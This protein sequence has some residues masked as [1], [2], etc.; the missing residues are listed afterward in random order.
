MSGRRGRGRGG[1]RYRGRSAR[2]ATAGGKAVKKTA[3]AAPTPDTSEAFQG[4]KTLIQRGDEQAALALLTECVTSAGLSKLSLEEAQDEQRYS[5]FSERDRSTQRT[6]L[7]Y[8]AENGQDRAVAFLLKNGADPE[9]CDNKRQ[10]PLDAAD[11]ALKNVFSAHKKKGGTTKNSNKGKHG[12]NGSMTTPA[13]ILAGGSQPSAVAGACLDVGTSIGPGHRTFRKGLEKT[14][15]VTARVRKAERIVI[16]AHRIVEHIGY[17]CLIETVGSGHCP[18]GAHI[19]ISRWVVRHMGTNSFCQ[20]MREDKSLQKQDALTLL[21]K[22]EHD[23][24]SDKKSNSEGAFL[25]PDSVLKIK[26][27]EPLDVWTVQFLL[28]FLVEESANFRYIDAFTDVLVTQGTE[29]LR[30]LDLKTYENIG[31]MLAITGRRLLYNMTRCGDTDESG[32]DSDEE[33]D[34][35]DSSEEAFFMSLFRT[36]TLALLP[37]LGSLITKCDIED[38]RLK[39]RMPALLSTESLSTFAA[40]VIGNDRALLFLHVT[41]PLVNLFVETFAALELL[42]E[43]VQNMRRFAIIMRVF[44]AWGQLCEEICMLGGKEEAAHHPLNERGPKTKKSGPKKSKKQT[45]GDPW[46]V[47]SKSEEAFHHAPREDDTKKKKSATKIS[48]KQAEDPLKSGKCPPKVCEGPG[49]ASVGDAVVDDLSGQYQSMFLPNRFEGVEYLGT[50]LNRRSRR[51]SQYRFDRRGVTLSVAQKFLTR[52][53]KLEIP[54]VVADVLVLHKKSLMVMVQSEPVL[55]Q[56]VLDIL[57][58]VPSAVS[59][60]VKV[61]AIIAAIRR[62]RD[63]G[64]EYSWP[65]RINR[66]VDMTTVMETVVQQIV[67]IPPRG[68]VGTLNVEFEGEDGIGDGPVREFFDL[69]SKQLLLKPIGGEIP[70]FEEIQPGVLYVKRS[71][72]AEAYSMQRV[73]GKLSKS[74]KKKR[75]E[76]T[77]WVLQEAPEFAAQIGKHVY[78]PAFGHA[79]EEICR[80]DK[81]ALS[82]PLARKIVSQLLNVICKRRLLYQCV[83]RIMGLAVLTHHPLSVN[84]SPLVFKQLLQQDFV[85]EDMIDVDPD[86]WKSLNK[87]K[88]DKSSFSTDKDDAS[89]IMF[90]SIPFS[91]TVK[92]IAEWDVWNT[93]IF[94]RTAGAV[95]WKE[96]A[97][98]LSP[99]PLGYKDEVV[100]TPDNIVKYIEHASKE[101][102]LGHRIDAFQSM[103]QGLHE[104]FPN[105]YLQLFSAQELQS[106]V[107]GDD[108][109]LNLDELQSEVEYEGGVNSR[110]VIIRWFWQWAKTLDANSKRLLL[111]FWS[112]SSRPPLHGFGSER[113]NEF[114]SDIEPVWTIKLDWSKPAKKGRVDEAMMKAATCD[115]TLALPARYTTYHALA[116]MCSLAIAYGSSGFE[117]A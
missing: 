93:D 114:D 63:G 42:F 86:I 23:K 73:C 17:I 84:I 113:G 55:A 35:P 28:G 45:V 78:A 101:F 94:V 57:L 67:C 9:A 3:V 82:H 66:M 56:S 49:V 37:Q 64:E 52:I 36:I 89:A 22:V 30:K 61:E 77:K 65:L 71:P 103:R 51:D 48:K 40:K 2:N 60:G 85:P 79:Y 95:P 110:H 112:G 70:L 96:S 34:L 31:N 41:M 75:T 72:V 59:T 99:R 39:I 68:L 117:N 16:A 69:M 26:D 104:V 108:R 33:V 58:K 98:G 11:K 24:R 29:S 109:E 80:A 27:A 91:D 87:M 83:G 10:S 88:D 5:I 1:V 7:H 62:D 100:V 21:I 8:A 92:G 111:L 38:I 4:L 90:S 102:C 13:D 43:E 50:R 19:P 76:V 53:T 97:Y 32:I 15:D 105:K 20:I 44:V 14:D 18:P 115:R 106:L 12:G 107:C 6:L 46:A 47:P 74:E 54:P 81:T 116:K 25:P